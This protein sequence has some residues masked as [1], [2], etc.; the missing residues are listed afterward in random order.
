MTLEVRRYEAGD[1]AAWD[2][3]VRRSRSG[4]FLFLRPYMEYH[5]DRFED[6]SMVVFRGGRL[7]AALP[8]NRDGATVVSHGGLTFGGLLTDAAMSTGRVLDAFSQVCAQLAR[9][10]LEALLYKPVPHI[11][12]RIPAAEGL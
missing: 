5:A 1:E 4:H 11:Y 8:A 3:L 12:H 10:G 6:H 7:V 2:E 9:A